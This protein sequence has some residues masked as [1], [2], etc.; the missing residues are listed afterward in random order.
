VIIPPNHF[1]LVCNWTAPL[2]DS[3]GGAT[4]LGF[5]NDGLSSPDIAAAAVLSAIV[6]ELMPIT[7]DT[8][9]LTDARW[10]TQTLGGL[11]IA[12]SA[13]GLTSTVAQPAST[14]LL[15]KQTGARGPRGRGRS[16][17]PQMAS[18]TDVD[19]AGIVTPARL[20]AI[21][22]SL[23]DFT[24]ALVVADLVQV[25]L[26]GDEGSSAV[27]DPPPEVTGFFCDPKIATQRRRL[28][29]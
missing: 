10:A 5:R 1:Q 26:Q 21:N 15:R 18:E 4:T 28:R 6:A 8:V 24:A 25:I 11:L 17:W 27:I 23:N 12:N 16:Y 3:G 22:A 19:E 29:R 20:T 2:W 9:T 14:M 13:G 7:T